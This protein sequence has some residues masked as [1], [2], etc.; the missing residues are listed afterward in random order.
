MI[1]TLAIIPAR[2][3]SKRIPNKN[4]RDFLGKPL[5]TW[6]IEF[7][8]SYKN[9]DDV[10]V[11]TDSAAIANIAAVCG[12]PV[13]WLRP[14]ELASDEATTLDVVLHALDCCEK[15]GQ[16][17]DYVALLQPTTP[18][19]REKVWDLA[20]QKLDSG[21]P[22]AV[23]VSSLD[24]HPYWTYWLSEDDKMQPCYPGKSDLRSQNLPNAVTV[25]GS[26]YLVKV[27]VLRSTRSF[28]PDGVC[29]VF[30]DDKFEALDIDTE[31]DWFVAEQLLS[32]SGLMK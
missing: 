13:P 11:T 24:Y 27:D 30:V 2:A 1:K 10:L 8:T 19:R 22:A 23:G 18:F 6:T 29:A 25:N 20:K 28:T 31:L 16:S 7:A 17:Y 21:A 12:K 3:G 14:A 32:E 9:F 26:L 5:V 15:D 4:V